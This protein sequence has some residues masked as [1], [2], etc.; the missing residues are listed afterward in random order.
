V[1]Q[2]ATLET[3]N[4]FNQVVPRVRSQIFRSFL[5]DKANPG[6]PLLLSSTD[7]RTPKV[8]QLLADPRAEVVWWMEGTREQYRLASSIY[9]IPAPSTPLYAQCTAAFADAAP[10][11]AMHG[12]RGHDWEETRRGTFTAM[13]PGMRATWLRPA[14]GSVL[15]GGQK[16]AESWH[17]SLDEPD[18]A[19]EGYEE[20]KR[21]WDTALSH[22]TLVVIDPLE[23]DMVELGVVPNRRTLF[24]KKEGAPGVWEELELVP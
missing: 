2:I 20:A 16:E 10:E 23:V 3:L 7:V 6:L 18:P 12:F 4:I 1:I 17:K 22:F 21:L 15:E 9:L 13:S 5:E 19:K 8:S 14:P 11:S 24:K